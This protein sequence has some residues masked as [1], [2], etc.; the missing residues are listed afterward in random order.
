ME[1][2]T[3]GQKRIKISSRDNLTVIKLKEKTADLI[4][5]LQTLKNDE[6]SKTYNNP[7]LTEDLSSEVIYLLE[8]AQRR[9]EEACMYALKAIT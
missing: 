7:Q 6:L 4:D 1:I 9:Y 3:I 5:F 2:Q 8:T